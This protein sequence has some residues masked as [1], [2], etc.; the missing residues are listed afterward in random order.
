M[1]IKNAEAQLL[2]TVLRSRFAHATKHQV[3]ELELGSIV[4]VR[5]IEEDPPEEAYAILVTYRKNKKDTMLAS[6]EGFDNLD[7]GYRL[8]NSEEVAHLVS[9]G[10]DSE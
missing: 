6:L 10:D 1:A 4:I 3:G 8:K 2:G 9:F 5:C 7:T